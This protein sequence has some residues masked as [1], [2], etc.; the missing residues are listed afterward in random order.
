MNTNNNMLAAQEEQSLDPVTY[1]E[2]VI[3][4][5]NKKEKGGATEVERLENF[6]KTKFEFRYNTVTGVL[7]YRTKPVE[8]KSFKVIKDRDETTIWR[9]IQK[10]ISSSEDKGTFSLSYLRNLL[11]S[12]FTTSYDP[13]NEYILAL[14]S[15][16]NNTDYIDQLANTVKTDNDK[17]FR[18]CL[19]V[20]LVATVG[21]FIKPE[22]I[23]HTALIFSG[24]QGIGKSTWMLNLAPKALKG[25]VYTGTINPDNKDTL[26]HMATNM[27]I[28]LDELENLNSTEV[29][30]IKE[31][32]TKPNIKLR[33]PYGRNTE[34]MPR[35][36]SFVGSVNSAQ[37]LNDST[38]S[39]RF[40]C[41]ESLEIEYNHGVD[42]DKVYA[43]AYALFNQGFKFWLDLED[44]AE[45][46]ANNSKFQRSTVEEDLVLEVFQPA[47]EGDAACLFYTTTQIARYV[48][49]STTGFQVNNATIKRLGSALKKHGFKTYKRSGSQKYA[50]M[51]K[52]TQSSTLEES[53][54]GKVG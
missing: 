20:W 4:E 41:F 40:L 51:L 19:K 22:I 12:D 26:I 3:W 42:M 23:N 36:A 44:I 32:I 29:G 17:L 14:P 47:K 10:R 11:N 2:Y 45:L 15:W 5:K 53:E 38:G 7:E 49:D 35:R 52:Q 21:S 30:A 8:G 39:R 1:I 27:L 43:Q 6:L 33:R 13:F 18:K 46:E 16:N 31:I 25:Y 48:A 50:V 9:L 54:V 37:F 24:K 28:N 34:E